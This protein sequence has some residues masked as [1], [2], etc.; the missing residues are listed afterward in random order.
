M[1][2]KIII[3]F[4]KLIFKTVCILTHLEIVYNV[5]GSI[6]QIKRLKNV[7]QYQIVN[8]FPIAKFM[9]IINNVSYVKR[10]DIFQMENVKQLKNQQITV[11]VNLVIHNVIYVKMNI[12]LIQI[13]KV[14]YQYQ[15][16]LLVEVTIYLL[17]LI[18]KKNIF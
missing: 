10:V 11:E 4:K 18:V 14:V 5:K 1:Y 13:E 7:F 12:Y 6:T 16:F 17:V 15:E 8:R 9:P 3:V 2:Q